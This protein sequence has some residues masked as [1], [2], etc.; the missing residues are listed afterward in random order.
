MWAVGL[1]GQRVPC[2]KSQHP[3]GSPIWARRC[4]GAVLGAGPPHTC[5]S[6]TPMPSLAAQ[7]PSPSSLIIGPEECQVKSW[8]GSKLQFSEQTSLAVELKSCS[9]R[10]W[11]M[12]KPLSMGKAT[13]LISETSEH[14]NSTAQHELDKKTLNYRFT[15]VH[16]LWAVC[17]EGSIMK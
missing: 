17:R 16:A 5:R 15:T 4:G 10:Q 9:K 3:A 12:L 7:W 11:K 6:S 13:I 2:C 14:S 8:Y 1:R